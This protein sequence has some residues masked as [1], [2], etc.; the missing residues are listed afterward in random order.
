MLNRSEQ[1]IVGLVLIGILFGCSSEKYQ[2]P[3]TVRTMPTDGVSS[4]PQKYTGGNATVAGSTASSTASS[5]DGSTPCD[6]VII[7]GAC[8]ALR[9]IHRCRSNFDTAFYT[10]HIYVTDAAECTA[11]GYVFESQTY[12]YAVT[13]LAA[14][15][16]TLVRWQ[17][18][19]LSGNIQHYYLQPGETVPAG[20]AQDGPTFTI[21][22]SDF[23]HP[24]K[25]GLFRCVVNCEKLGSHPSCD[26]NM[27]WISLDVNCE[28]N[29]TGVGSLLGYAIAP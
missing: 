8:Q 22:G 24:R 4:T 19:G 25:I 14:T 29:G 7:N 27:Q 2:G 5:N 12:F 26:P 13:G 6:G 23:S 15:G 20:L 1:I 10:N 16:K 28:G 3:V 21:S 9:A 17:R 11:A 18:T